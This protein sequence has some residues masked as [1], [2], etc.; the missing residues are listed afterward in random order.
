MHW[1]GK[2]FGPWDWVSKKSSDTNDRRSWMKIAKKDGK[3]Y[4]LIDGVAHGPFDR[5]GRKRWFTI[6]H[7]AFVCTVIRGREIFLIEGGR[8]ERKG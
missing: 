6:S 4:L 1:L 5:F 3:L 8:M 2:E 7:N